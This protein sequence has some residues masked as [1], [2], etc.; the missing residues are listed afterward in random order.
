M[1]EAAAIYPWRALRTLLRH[2]DDFDLIAW[3]LYDKILGLDD[4]RGLV[5]LNDNNGSGVFLPLGAE[6]VFL[7]L[8]N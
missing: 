7:D 6:V 1:V 3:N 5:W 2:T 8:K 4:Y